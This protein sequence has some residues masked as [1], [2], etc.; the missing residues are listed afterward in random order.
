MSGSN[1]AFYRIYPEES[2]ICQD[3]LCYA[4]QLT[5]KKSITRQLLIIKRR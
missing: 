4:E 2:Q 3:Y 1:K 5:V